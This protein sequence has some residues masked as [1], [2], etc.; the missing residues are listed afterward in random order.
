M[1]KS[2]NIIN[3]RGIKKYMKRKFPNFILENRAKQFIETFLVF[4]LKDFI[5]KCCLLVRHRKSKILKVRD[6]K[7]Q[8][9]NSMNN[10]YSS[11]FICKKLI[12]N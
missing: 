7:T 12:K 10:F 11:L 5:K 9:F 8:I 6:L 2:K 4:Y 3:S 1:D